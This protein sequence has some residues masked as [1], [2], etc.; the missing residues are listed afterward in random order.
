MPLKTVQT[1]TNQ[2]GAVLSATVT[3]DSSE[4]VASTVTALKNSLGDKA[5]VTSAAYLFFANS[6]AP[7]ESIGNLTLVGIIGSAIYKEP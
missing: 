1:L 2:A 3:V 5:D 6:L 7:L 4:N